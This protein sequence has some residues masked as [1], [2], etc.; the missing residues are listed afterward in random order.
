MRVALVMPVYNEA[1]TLAETVMEI[2]HAFLS[3]MPNTSLHIFEDGSTDNTKMAL[4]DLAKISDRIR[5]ST[6]QTRKGYPKAA[7]DAILSVDEALYDYILFLDSDGQYDPSDFSKLLKIMSEEP[8]DMINGRRK[9]RAEPLYRTYLSSG[10]NTM[11]KIFFDIRCNDVTSA[12]RLMKIDVAKKIAHKVRYS[13]Y[14]FWLE[15]TAR[16]GEEGYKTTEIPVNYRARKGKQG[17][18]VYSAW[19]MPKIVARELSALV[20]TWWECKGFQALKFAAVGLAGA[21]MILA[22]SFTFTSIMHQNYLF[23]TAIAIEVSILWA[24]AFNDRWTF[25]KIRSRLNRGR[26]LMRY[27]TISLVGLA[28]NLSLFFV[29]VRIGTYY[30]AAESLAIILTFAVNYLASSRWAWIR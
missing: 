18:N 7:R 21:T 26:R 15:F 12:L 14:S 1:Q 19:K 6:S 29:L 30:L 22:L 10:L 23:S 28:V 20:R 24:F 16:G 2:F 4:T 9:N 8:A 17:S 13:P 11:E 3:K 5:I 25:G 27:N